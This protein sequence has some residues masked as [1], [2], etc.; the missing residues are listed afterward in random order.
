MCYV[1]IGTPR[2]TRKAPSKPSRAP[3]PKP[4]SPA[5]V[6]GSN[7]GNPRVALS[8]DLNSPDDSNDVSDGPAERAAVVTTELGEHEQLDEHYKK[9]Q[10]DTTAVVNR[11]E[12]ERA[13]LVAAKEEAAV[14][15]TSC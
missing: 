10:K 7:P 11:L 1:Y 4:K 12:S 5:P 15:A 6:P 8:V 13:S 2:P 9:D 3:P 14:T